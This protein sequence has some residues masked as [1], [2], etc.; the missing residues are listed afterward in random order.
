MDGRH[1][2]GWVRAAAAPSAAIRAAPASL[3][4]QSGATAGCQHTQSRCWNG[5]KPTVRNVSPDCTEARQQQL[6]CSAAAHAS[7]QS[8]CKRVGSLCA[9]HAAACRTSTRSPVRG[10]GRS[11]PRCDGRRSV[12][13]RCLGGPPL[14]LQSTRR[15]NMSGLR[16]VCRGQKVRYMISRSVGIIPSPSHGTGFRQNPIC[17][18][19]QPSAPP[20]C[21]RPAARRRPAASAWLPPPQRQPGRL[22]PPAAGRG[23]KG[24]A[25][26]PPGTACRGFRAQCTSAP[27]VWL[28]L[29]DPQA[30]TSELH[31]HL[32]TCLTSMSG[33]RVWAVM[34]ARNGELS[35]F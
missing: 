30:E 3:P 32:S 35:P 10:I 31:K 23:R 4:A 8:N 5:R 11:R 26:S 28:C 13:L 7:S 29:A 17:Q 9:R 24:T 20:A 27:Q 15:V 18:A 21:R 16:V 6:L 33:L 19:L 14:F 12:G 22:L 25:H 2:T 1:T 34:R